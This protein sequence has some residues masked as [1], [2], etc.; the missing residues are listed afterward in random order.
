MMMTR[1][2]WSSEERCPALAAPLISAEQWQQA[3]VQLAAHAHV[4]S[5]LCAEAGLGLA[6]M[7]MARELEGRARMHRSH[8]WLMMQRKGSA[9][10]AP[11][12]ARS[13]C[14]G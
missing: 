8:Y 5:L 12:G 9:A 11:C 1:H 2:D 4:A 6:L 14:P 10:F 7:E 3:L 13:C